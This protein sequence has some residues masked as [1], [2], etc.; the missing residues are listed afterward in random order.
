MGSSFL[1]QAVEFLSAG[2]SEAEPATSRHMFDYQAGHQL[3]RRIGGTLR[4]DP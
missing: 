3:S 1:F 2:V 4:L